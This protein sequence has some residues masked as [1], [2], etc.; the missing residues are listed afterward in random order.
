MPLHIDAINIG[1]VTWS[2]DA[3]IRIGWHWVQQTMGGV[4][5]ILP[6]DNLRIPLLAHETGPI[7]PGHGYAFRSHLVL[8][9]EP[10][11][12]IA[13]PQMLSELV[14]WFGTQ[15]PEIQVRVTPPTQ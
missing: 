2:G 5:R 1:P 9:K 7:R 13:R 8:P 3:N 6:G 10:G 11:D 4:D 14:A 12:Y 15:L